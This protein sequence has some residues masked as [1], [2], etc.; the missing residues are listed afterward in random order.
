MHKIM[1]QKCLNK[2][3]LDSDKRKEMDIIWKY[4]R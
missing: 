2:D 4:Q 3:H 1:H